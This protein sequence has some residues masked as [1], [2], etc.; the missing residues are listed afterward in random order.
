M[1]HPAMTKPPGREHRR[2]RGVPFGR[3]SLDQAFSSSD[4]A[5]LLVLMPP[6]EPL[7]PL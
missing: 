1:D 5:K 4:S 7:K 2:A 3:R 6:S